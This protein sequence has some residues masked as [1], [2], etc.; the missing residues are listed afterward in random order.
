MTAAV[1][2][3]TT[4]IPRPSRPAEPAGA[5]GTSL[6]ELTGPFRYFPSIYL[7]KAPEPETKELLA[8]LAAAPKGSQPWLA[9]RNQLVRR[10]LPLVKALA[11]RF[12]GRGEDLE[13]L[14]Q[15]ATIGLLK[16][17]DRYDP[18]RGAEFTTFATPT[19]TGE[20]QRHLRDRAS[21]LRLPRRIQE[22]RSAAVRASGELHQRLGR[23]PTLPELARALGSPAEAVAEA[24]ASELCTVPLDNADRADV[25]PALDSVEFRAALR[26]LLSRLPAREKRMVALRFFEHRTQ[27][28][29][30]AELGISQVQVSRLLARTLNG[31]RC[32]LS[33]GS[34]GRGPGGWERQP[35][36]RPREGPAG[37]PQ[38]PGRAG[39]P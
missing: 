30:A 27:S 29:I 15:V 4:M 28:E 31:L 36:S 23:A 32:A 25:D 13:D 21:T 16:A 7:D 18:D 22:L 9:L 34:P 2:A 3:G 24:L 37:S 26:P 1:L 35:P 8:R 10:H 12:R 19:M 5:A 38:P 11:R 33:D 14:V 6:P 39:H 17:M 20:L